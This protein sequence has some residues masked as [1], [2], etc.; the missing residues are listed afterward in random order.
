MISVPHPFTTLI[1]RETIQRYATDFVNGTDVHFAVA[2]ASCPDDLVGYVGT[3]H[4]D[5]AHLEGELSFWMGPSVTGRGFATEAA[6]AALHFGFDALGLNRIC[7][8]HMVK[9]EA[10]KRVL[11]RLGMQQEGYLRQRVLKHGQ[12]EDVLVWAILRVD[13]DGRESPSW[14]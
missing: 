6:M 1:A 5:R 7:A 13:A 3:H 8:Y 11:M 10:S 14:R 9:N 4:I 12:F 2:E